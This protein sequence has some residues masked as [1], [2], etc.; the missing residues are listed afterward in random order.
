[1]VDW[2]R[3]EQLR[4]K[5]WDWDQIADDEKVGFHP[6]SSV[7][8]P[9]R[10]LRGLYH[11]QR[12]RSGRSGGDGGET[13]GSGKTAVV[14]ERIWTLP[15]IGYL[16][17]PVFGLWALLAY[18][19]PSP[20]GI[21]LPA[22][23]WLAIAVAVAAFILLFGLLR[24]SGKRWTPVFRSTLITGII[25]G[26]VIAG[27]VGVT[28][29]LAFGCP[30]LPPT[31]GSQ[32]APGWGYASASPWQDGGK[33][34]F[35]FYGATWCPYCS[36]SSWALWKALTEFQSGFNGATNGVPG[37]S[38]MY[39]SDDAAG[40]YTPEVVLASAQVSSPVV[41]FQV[42]EYF[43]TQ[44]S[45]T[46]GTFPGTSNCVQQAYVTAYSGGA[47]PFVVVNGQYVHGGTSLIQPSVMAT[48]SAGANGGYNTVAT[49]VLQESAAPWSSV[50]PQA[51]WLCAYILKANGYTSVSAFLTANPS[52]N[53]PGKYQ[54]TSA[55]TSTV[56]GDLAQI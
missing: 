49:N 28:G 24:S 32:P 10:A 42:S 52:L 12:A 20:V 48:W 25:L 50:E 26:L 31:L 16:L 8:D 41:S 1:M 46:E 55:M 51:A 56:N 47:I 5:G 18:L 14:G 38:L 37:T 13:R 45:G 30:Y 54:W 15:R 2:D 4:S 34:V 35:Y 3:V 44:T 43:W 40:P 36:A 53:N 19:A 9:G 33:P 27:L 6:E 11:R 21:L 17:F 7:R 39:S 23:P 22:I 29:Y